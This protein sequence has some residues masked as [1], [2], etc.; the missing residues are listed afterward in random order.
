MW[1]YTTQRTLS[2]SWAARAGELW[3]VVREQVS[4]FWDEEY[5]LQ[6]SVFYRWQRQLVDN[7]EMALDGPGG[8]PAPRRDARL[9]T[10]NRQLRARLAQKDG[11]IAEISEEYVALKKARGEL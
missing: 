6:P 2:L 11:V 4:S 7:L 5:G 1:V 8:R 9:E 10:E 3:D